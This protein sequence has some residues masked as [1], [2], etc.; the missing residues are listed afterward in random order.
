MHPPK[1]ALP[2]R[3]RKADRGFTLIELLTVI[4]I[5]GILAAII[6]PVTGEVRE[7]AK[8]SKCAATQRQIALAILLYASANKDTLPGPVN[9]DISAPDP[10]IPLDDT[11]VTLRNFIQPYL[12]DKSDNFWVCPANSAAAEANNNP[13]QR[14]VYLL[15]NGSTVQKSRPFGNPTTGALPARL[16]Q[17]R[18]ARTL[19]STDMPLSRIWMLADID[20][21]NFGSGSPSLAG[22]KVPPPHRGG[23]NYAYFDGHVAYEKVGVGSGRNGFLLSPVGMPDDPL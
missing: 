12:G 1:L 21:R 19:V 16:S 5:I 3:R 20:S 23:R 8:A 7:S 13:T 17:I 22:K 6:I 18:T 2:P 10:D 11:I 4:A 14:F 15:N 9:R